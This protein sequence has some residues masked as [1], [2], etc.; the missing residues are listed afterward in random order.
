L[1]QTQMRDVEVLCN[2]TQ[3]LNLW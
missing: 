2:W 1:N 3:Y